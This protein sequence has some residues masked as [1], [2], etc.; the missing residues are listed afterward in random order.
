MR[1]IYR[2]GSLMST[3]YFLADKF[4]PRETQNSMSIDT[5]SP[6]AA[7]DTKISK[8]SPFVSGVSKL[9]AKGG[10]I[11]TC[12]GAYCRDGECEHLCVVSWRALALFL[13]FLNRTSQCL[14][15]HNVFF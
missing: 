7:R 4:S 5:S 12:R 10:N 15:V 13:S 2:N 1:C 3:F 9:W 11:F 6:S 8:P 14:N